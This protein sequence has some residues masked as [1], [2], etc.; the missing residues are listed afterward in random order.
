MDADPWEL[1][2]FQVMQQLPC[3]FSTEPI[4]ETKGILAAQGLDLVVDHLSQVQGP[5]FIIL[6]FEDC[7]EYVFSAEDKSVEG[8]RS[9]ESEQ[10]G[11][12]GMVK[13]DIVFDS[14]LGENGL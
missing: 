7:L 10:E 13:L 5:L 4:S 11:V 8:E 1:A 14:P 3:H 6:C 12:A 2:E 9:L